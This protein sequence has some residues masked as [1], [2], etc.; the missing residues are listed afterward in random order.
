MR[1]DAKTAKVKVEAKPPVAPRSLKSEDSR[2]RQLQKRL[3]EALKREAEAL[4]QQTATA[5]ILRVISSSPTDVQPVFD[6]ML[7][8]A[9]R[10]CDVPYGALSRLQNDQLHLVSVKGGISANG[11]G[12]LASIF[13]R[14]IDEAGLLGRAPAGD[15]RGGAGARRP[16]PRGAPHAGGEWRAPGRI[17]HAVRHQGLVVRRLAGY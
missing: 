14:S 2:V 4:E 7:E 10:I 12:T 9:V 13:P 16:V 5:D 17:E 11:L 3:K 1:R 8:R 15:R 6:A